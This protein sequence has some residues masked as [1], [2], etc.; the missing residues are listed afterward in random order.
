MSAIFGEV[1]TFGQKN[2]PDVRLKVF[3]DEHYARYETSTASPSSTTSSVGLFCYARL[4]AGK[5]RSTGVAISDRR[6]R[7]WS[8]TCR[9]RTLSA[10][11]RPE[12]RRIAKTP[13]G[14]SGEERVVRTFGPNQGLLEG[15]RAQRSAR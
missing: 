15:R 5:F 14:N 4:A 6:R 2:G 10:M 8:V 3:G 12:A 7:A 11:P 1:L 13:V 9:S